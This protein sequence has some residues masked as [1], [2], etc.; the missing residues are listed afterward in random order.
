MDLSVAS[1]AMDPPGVVLPAIKNRTRYNDESIDFL[2]R[3]TVAS[4]I[5][6]GSRY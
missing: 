5:D 1:V 3:R 6:G 2:Q 4:S